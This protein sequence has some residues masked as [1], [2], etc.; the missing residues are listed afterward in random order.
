MNLTR[1]SSKAASL[2]RMSSRDTAHGENSKWTPD[3]NTLPLPTLRRMIAGRPSP[4]EP[5][6]ST[7]DASLEM[8]KAG[9]PL[10][11]RGNAIESDSW[12]VA[13]WAP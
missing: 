8:S 6:T 1:S 5:S 7:P 2:P 11:Y 4:Y 9:P 10:K 13:A 12:T 3:N